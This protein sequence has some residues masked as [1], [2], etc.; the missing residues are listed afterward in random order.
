MVKQNMATGNENFTQQ[1]QY[2][3]LLRGT[4]PHI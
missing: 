2:N 3:K 4:G 1:V